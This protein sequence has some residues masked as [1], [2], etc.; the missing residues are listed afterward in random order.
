M[1]QGKEIKITSILHEKYNINIM[2]SIGCEPSTQEIDDIK[3]KMEGMKHEIGR[4]F[5][6]SSMSTEDFYR[7][8][9]NPVLKSYC[10]ANEEDLDNLD[11]Q[12][13]EIVTL[14]NEKLKECLYGE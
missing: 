9:Y 8:I 5:H 6:A 4:T 3:W 10:D 11:A 14:I 13:L 12:Y 7:N 2:D 1:T